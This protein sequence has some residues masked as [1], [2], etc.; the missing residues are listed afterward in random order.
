[1]KYRE[2]HRLAETA[3]RFKTSEKTVKKWWKRWDGTVASLV[4]QSRRPKNSPRQTSEKMLKH[5]RRVLKKH[6]WQDLL[7][8]YQ[9]MVERWEYKGSYGGFKVI[10]RKLRGLKK[11]KKKKARKKV[12]PYRRAEYPGQKVQLDVKFVPGK[13]V[14]NG[15]KYYQFTAVDECTRWAFREI[16]DEHS[17]FS[18]TD[19]LLKFITSAPFPI[20][21][22]QTD[23]GTEFTNALLVVKSKHKSL[24]ETAL[25]EMGIQ[26][27][28]IRIAT[29]RH[30]GK[31]ERQHRTDSQRFY[32][33]LRMFSLEDG[34]RQLADY[35]RRSNNHMK[36]CLNLRSPNDV[37]ADYLAIM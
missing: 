35:Q 17:T 33:R 2:S 26:Y 37:L 9:E 15:Q 13:C 14:V 18:A 16:Y 1:M 8:S 19:F 12:K 11:P 4:N 30:N 6:R 10:A 24:F 22:I 32:S 27:Q 34:R 3:I 25:E 23:N 5:M 29:P 28:R 31:V 7:L 21:K 20:H 36:T